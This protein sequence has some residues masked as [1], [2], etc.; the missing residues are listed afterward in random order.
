MNEYDWEGKEMNERNRGRRI[1][2]IRKEEMGEKRIFGREGKEKNRRGREE[3][4][5]I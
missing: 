3:K 4:S 5:I 1:E 2:E